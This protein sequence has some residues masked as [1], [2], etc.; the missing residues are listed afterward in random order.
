MFRQFINGKGKI[1]RAVKM[2]WVRKGVGLGS[3]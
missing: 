2:S 3:R 1:S